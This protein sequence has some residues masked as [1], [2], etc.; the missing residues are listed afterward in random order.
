MT[1]ANP[2]T[3]PDEAKLDVP[4]KAPPRAGRVSVVVPTRN[5]ER[6]LRACLESVRAQDHQDV[7]V[8]V[9][10]NRSTDRT[11]EIARSLS[12]VVEQA[13]PERSAQRNRGIAVSTGDWVMWVDADMVL[14][15]TCVSTATCARRQLWRGGRRDP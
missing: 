8:V 9:V 5:A 13:G 15:L 1:L 6:T 4:A 11:P 10:D 12:D 3:M 14:G 7:Q 2:G